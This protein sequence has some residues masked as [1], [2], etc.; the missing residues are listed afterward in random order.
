MKTYRLTGADLNRAVAMA[1]GH[2]V[3]HYRTWLQTVNEYW[4]G[5]DCSFA[6]LDEYRIMEP[7]D[8]TSSLT[9]PDYAGDISVAWPI[10]EKYNISLDWRDS[11]VQCYMWSPTAQDFGRTFYASK[12]LVLHAAM[13]CFVASVYGDEISLEN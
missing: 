7:N 13:R 2:K 5:R 3:C 8:G 11:E 6:P 9:I 1:L 4:K 10:I 12:A